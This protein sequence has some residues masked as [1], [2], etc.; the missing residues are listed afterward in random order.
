MD[1]MDSTDKKGRRQATGKCAVCLRRNEKPP[2][3]VRGLPSI[4]DVEEL[5]ITGPF[6]SGS[7]E[8]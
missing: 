2:R 4:R 7:R 5:M 3:G 8:A 1:R 6:K